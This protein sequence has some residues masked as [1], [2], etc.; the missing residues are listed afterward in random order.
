MQ[1]KVYKILHCGNFIEETS[2]V[3]FGDSVRILKVF[4]G[5]LSVTCDLWVSFGGL[6]LDLWSTFGRPLGDLWA[7]FGKKS[8]RKGKFWRRKKRKV[9][10]ENGKVESGKVE[11]EK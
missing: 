7:T 2:K 6:V 3:L 1:E 9:E 8:E 5:Y 10:R 4:T 11:R